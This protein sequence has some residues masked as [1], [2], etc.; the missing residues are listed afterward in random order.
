MLS[1]VYLIL[2][3]PLGRFAV[4]RGS[5]GRT[6]ATRPAAV[7]AHLRNVARGPVDA[8]RFAVAF[9]WQRYL[10]PGRKVPGFYVRS[11]ANA[12]PLVY[13]GEHLPQRDS[14]V[15]LSRERDALGVP[16]LETHLRFA[17]GELEDA[18]RAYRHVDAHL[19]RHGVGR[20]ELVRR[21]RRGGAR[22]ALRRLPPGGHHADGAPARGRRGR[23]GR[24]RAH[25]A[26]LHVAS[27]SI[28]PTSGQA[29]ST[30][31]ALA[32]TLRL[33]DHLDATLRAAPVLRAA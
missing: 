16:R 17:E 3:S 5:A 32:L 21:S 11:A 12:Y 24:L 15:R 27:S 22:P 31:T 19:R 30:F 25:R 2:A 13:H 7:R 18:V 28:L 1:F 9:G 8:A 10:R 26:N 6:W 4:A 29:N 23:R 14:H 33:A 20:V